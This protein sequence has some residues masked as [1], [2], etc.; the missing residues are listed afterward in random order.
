M[1]MQFIT[2]GLRCFFRSALILYEVYSGLYILC[3]W[4]VGSGNVS[5]KLDLSDCKRIL[6]FKE[7]ILLFQHELQY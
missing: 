6:D 4:K 2:D 1:W 5:L 7:H 3:L